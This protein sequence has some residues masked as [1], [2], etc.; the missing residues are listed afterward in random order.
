M[1]S[2]SN[3]SVETLQS[4]KEKLYQFNKNANEMKVDAE[5]LKS[6]LMVILV[7][8]DHILFKSNAFNRV[9][10]HKGS[11]GVP[12]HK[13]C[14]LGKWYY[15]EAKEIFGFT[16]AYKQIEPPHATVHNAS[17][18]AEEL[19]KD[20]YNEKVAPFVIEKF[21]EMENA[22]MELFELLDEMLVEY[23][24]ALERKAQQSMLH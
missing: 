22:S 5:D 16:N 4:F 17:I 15:G 1:N 3:E 13:E 12:S 24:Q 20:G 10:T 9:I 6:A 11:Q 23:H 21:K 8:I 2:V 7:K 19:F 14:R 18:E